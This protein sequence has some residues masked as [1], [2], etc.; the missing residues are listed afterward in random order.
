[1]KFIDCIVN[2][3]IIVTQYSIKRVCIDDMMVQQPNLDVLN[4][5]LEDFFNKLSEPMESKYARLKSG[6]G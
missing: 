4:P 6:K 5:T 1:M 2:I 3:F